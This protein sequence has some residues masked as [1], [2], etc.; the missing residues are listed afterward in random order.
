MVKLTFYGG[1]NEIGGNKIL[2]EDKSTRILIDF[3]MSYG[4]KAQFFDDY[5]RPRAACGLGDF[6][7]SGLIP[8]L[9]GVYRKDLLETVNRSAED[10]VVD[11][12]LLSHAHLDHAAYISFLNEKIPVYCGE[13]CKMILEAVQEA[14]NRD[15]ETEILSFKPRP[16]TRKST[17]VS[18]RFETFRTGKSFMIGD[19]EITP[20]H[21]DHSIPGDYA[22]LIRT[23][24]GVVAYTSD[25]RMH[26]TKPEMTEDFVQLAEKVEPVALISEGTRINEMK[27]DAGEPGVRSGCASI[28]QDA[29][30]LVV[31]DFNFKDVDRYHTFESIAKENDRKL[32]IPLKDAYFLKHLNKDAQLGL[33]SPDDSSIVLIR[34]RRGTGQYVDTDY[35]VDDRQFLKNQ[36]CVKV[37]ELSERQDEILACLG[38]FDMNVIADMKP[39]PG[40]IYVHSSSEAYNEEMVLDHNRLKRWTDFLGMRYCQSHASGHASGMDI[41]KMIRRIRP[42]T[43]FPIHTE[44]S[45][46]FDGTAKNVVRIEQGKTY[47]L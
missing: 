6:L 2:L 17:E 30:E 14:G 32:A 13:T 16:D 22:F 34:S 5:V 29:E 9:Q 7:R 43:V 27:S 15:L 45:G 42:K 24:R 12:V 21:V 33:P 18:R 4:H 23:S 20:V 19:L 1:V 28:I 11:A 44:S 3:G 38:Y 36:N 46:S 35:G 37:E 31:A 26:G 39:A 41:M 40:S 25:L 10:P 8:D 47:T